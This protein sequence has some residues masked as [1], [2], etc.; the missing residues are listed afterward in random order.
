[1][2]RVGRASKLKGHK[3]GRFPPDLLKNWE[4]LLR[5]LFKAEKT[6]SNCDSARISM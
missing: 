5:K 3:I 6:I 2:L 4:I 1:M